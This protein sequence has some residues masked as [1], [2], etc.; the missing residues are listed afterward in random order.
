MGDKFLALHRAQPRLWG[1]QDYHM[2]LGA[3][4]GALL[5]VAWARRIMRGAPFFWVACRN[6]DSIRAV[7]DHPAED[8]CV[9]CPQH[10][11]YRCEC[12]AAVSTRRSP[13]TVIA[14]DL[15]ILCGLTTIFCS[16]QCVQNAYLPTSAF[17]HLR[18]W[19]QERP[20]R[21]RFVRAVNIF[22][23]I[24]GRDEV[25]VDNL[26]RAHGQH[27]APPTF[28]SRWA[29]VEVT[30]QS[31]GENNGARCTASTN[32]LLMRCRDPAGA[33]CSLDA[34]LPAYAISHRQAAVNR[35]FGN[36]LRG[37]ASA[38]DAVRDT[39]VVW[40]GD[41]RNNTHRGY[42]EVRRAVTAVLCLSVARSERLAAAEADD[43]DVNTAAEADAVKADGG[44]E[45]VESFFDTTAFASQQDFQHWLDTADDSWVYTTTS[46]H[47][48]LFVAEHG[49]HA[50]FT[51]MVAA[52]G[53]P[54]GSAGFH[55]RPLSSWS[56]L[57]MAARFGFS[58]MAFWDLDG[59]VYLFFLRET[60][61]SA[62]R[63]AA[64]FMRHTYRFDPTA[65]SEDRRAAAL[66]VPYEWSL[67]RFIRVALFGD[68]PWVEIV[69]PSIAMWA[70]GATDC[71]FPELVNHEQAGRLIGQVW[72]LQ[73]PKLPNLLV[74]PVGMTRVRR[75][76]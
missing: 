29:R 14:G 55:L 8:A 12:G 4:T 76:R 33:T 35:Q 34:V 51:Q 11:K 53:K 70:R 49:I 19:L 37:N 48:M 27:G 64:T 46:K 68:Y 72:D 67:G 42:P 13:S 52:A 24:A 66:C 40:W 30:K 62:L 61:D 58:K 22:G 21:T 56:Q 36:A 5:D 75:A 9:S 65:T 47:D 59:D 26:L 1:A 32:A 10:K 3:T 54:G 50:I 60:P 15:S 20:G 38:G 71:F 7:V 44:I 28:S 69:L 63:R 18:L 39:S 41:R 17:P 43:E 2:V 16:I 74:T 6:R 57:E 23:G 73:Q 45:I 31:F 25:L